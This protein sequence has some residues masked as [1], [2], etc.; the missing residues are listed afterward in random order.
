MEAMYREG[1]RAAI[2]CLV[3]RATSYRRDFYAAGRAIAGSQAD[4]ECRDFTQQLVGKWSPQ[5]VRLAFG[6]AELHL[7]ASM[8]HLLALDSILRLEAVNDSTATLCRGVTESSAR[9]GWL[10]DPSIDGCERVKRAM[11][12]R[13]DALHWR[14]VRGRRTNQDIAD[15][16]GQMADILTTAKN[17]GFS[18]IESNTDRRAPSLVSYPGK[19]KAVEL[20][21]PDEDLGLHGYADMSAVAHSVPASLARASVNA[22]FNDPISAGRVFLGEG[23]SGEFPPALGVYTAGIAYYEAVSRFLTMFGWDRAM[24]EETAAIAFRAIAVVVADTSE[25]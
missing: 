10:L 18:I 8:D 4:R 23:A 13:L 24:W 14:C 7:G 15:E 6:M 3:V 22:D 11:S 25:S 17:L 1:M 5:P 20:L 12:E 19:S 9:A 21:I 2:Q 16:E